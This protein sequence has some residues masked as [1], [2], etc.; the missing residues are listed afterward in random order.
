MLDGLPDM[1]VV[2]TVGSGNNILQKASL[3]KASCDSYGCGFDKFQGI[4]SCRVCKK[5]NPGSKSD[6]NGFCTI[7]IGY[8]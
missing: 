3:L 7:A 1:H 6:R 4:F 2:A 8:C 5:R